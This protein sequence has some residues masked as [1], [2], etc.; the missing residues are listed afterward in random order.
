MSIKLQVKRFW[1]EQPVCSWLDFDNLLHLSELVFVKWQSQYYVFHKIIVE[2]KCGYL[3]SMAITTIIMVA[4]WFYRSK[5]LYSF[6]V[7]LYRLFSDLFSDPQAFLSNLDSFLT[8]L[9]S[10]GLPQVF[11][12]FSSL[13][14]TLFSQCPLT[15]RWQ[16]L[17][18]VPHGP[19]R[20]SLCF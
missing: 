2:S 13:Q 20:A 10:L 11:W 12:S 19:M 7:G 3:V 4:S 17:C 16:F 15:P 1:L 14:T 8:S 5:N 9:T 18:W 6:H